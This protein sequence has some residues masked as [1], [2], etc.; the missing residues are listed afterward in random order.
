ML[1]LNS[2]SAGQE[3][4]HFRSRWLQVCR[5]RGTPAPDTAQVARFLASLPAQELADLDRA[6]LL[7]LNGRDKHREL[8]ILSWAAA[9][10]RAAFVAQVHAQGLACAANDLFGAGLALMALGWDMSARVAQL[11]HH[12]E[13]IASLGAM[14]ALQPQVKSL[15]GAEVAVKAL[16]TKAEPVHL[17]T[18]TWSEQEQS[19]ACRPEAP[20]PWEAFAPTSERT[21]EKQSPVSA[22]YALQVEPAQEEAPAFESQEQERGRSPGEAGRQRPLQV[23]LFGKDAAHTLEVEPHRRASSFMGVQVVTIES[24]RAFGNGS[25]DWGRKLTVQ[26]TPEEMPE[27]I[28]VLMNLSS[29]VRFGQ[30]GADRDKF[31]ELRRQAGGM[32]VVTGQGSAVYAVPVKSGTLYYL[33]ALFARAMAGGLPG[34][35]IAEVLALVKASH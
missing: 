21:L 31:V 28:A 16:P 3:A 25:Y 10:T 27:A 15:E 8:E 4:D 11:A 2:K 24:A 7:C 5:T 33:L 9:C 6:L 34:S 1:M 13:D 30:H 23:R 26:L 18:P 29:S 32:V 35:S 22:A 19:R 17:A 14:L 20:E 12:P